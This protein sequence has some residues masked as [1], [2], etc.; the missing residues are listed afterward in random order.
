M[1]KAIILQHKKCL[2]ADLWLKYRHIMAVKVD[3][4]TAAIC[5]KHPF[6]E[7]E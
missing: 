1:L 7:T 2:I 4:N 6:I 3:V 5:M